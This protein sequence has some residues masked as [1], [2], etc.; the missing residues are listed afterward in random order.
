MHRRHTALLKKGSCAFL[1]FLS[2]K[3]GNAMDLP[4]F[5]QQNPKTAIAFSGGVDSA[6]LLYAA[7]RWGKE[8]LRLFCPFRFPA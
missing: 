7:K 1:R 5:F 6:Y 3:E 8:T 4:A 2:K